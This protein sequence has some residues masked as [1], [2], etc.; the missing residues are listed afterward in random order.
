MS[1]Q[2]M[3]ERAPAGQLPR[4]VDVLLDDDLVD[5]VKPGDRIQLVGIYKSLGN[6]AGE[7]SAIFRTMI[8]ANNVILLSSKSGGGIAQATITDTD[9]RNINK[10]AKNRRIFDQLSQSLAPSIYGHD[11][12]K[13]AILLMLLGGIEK[14]LD[15]GTHLRG[16]INVLMVGDPSTA[17]SQPVS[18]THL[19]LPTK[20]IV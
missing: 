5:R 15:N 12:I 16:D 18:Y 13:K 20:R 7:S 1:I 6:R 19:T 8:I 14:N 10:L 3:P 4:S 17:K 11:H 9:I 2:E